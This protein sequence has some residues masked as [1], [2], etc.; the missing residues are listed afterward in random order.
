MVIVLGKDKKNGRIV[1]TS[2]RRDRKTRKV[3]AGSEKSSCRDKK[4][5]KTDAGSAVREVKSPKTLQQEEHCYADDT[6]DDTENLFWFDPLFV[7]DGV[8]CNDKYRC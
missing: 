6:E 2:S 5:L 3:D 4:S 1:S 7:D 8:W